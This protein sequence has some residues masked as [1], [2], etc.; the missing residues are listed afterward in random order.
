MRD[1]KTD[2]TEQTALDA[3]KAG[4]DVPEIWL[5]YFVLAAVYD[6]SHADAWIWN[7]NADLKTNLKIDA[8]FL[9]PFIQLN[10]QFIINSSLDRIIKSGDIKTRFKVPKKYDLNY[11]K[12][13]LVLK[14][15]E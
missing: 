2:W 8:N 6:I 10:F 14:G 5:D 1:K 9:W 15:I 7:E 12:R 13:L 3:I 4:D 11:F